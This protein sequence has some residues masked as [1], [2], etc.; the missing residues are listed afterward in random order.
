MNTSEKELGIITAFVDKLKAQSIPNAL[1]LKRRI[2]LGE[3]L[4]R[5]DLLH[6][7]EQL[8]NAKNM[9]GMLNHH[10]EFQKLTDELTTL[11]HSIT[12]QALNNENLKAPHTF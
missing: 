12:E 1:E 11:Y 3:R 10:P 6:F 4:D 7:E 8:S 5:T 9:M 2:D